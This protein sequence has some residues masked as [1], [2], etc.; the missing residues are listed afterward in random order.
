V[1]FNSDVLQSNLQLAI[2]KAY[3]AC[4]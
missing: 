4:S 2:L 3:K 1:E